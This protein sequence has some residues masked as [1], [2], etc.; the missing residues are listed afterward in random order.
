MALQ[1]EFE[2]QGNWLF[3]YRGSLP[4]VVLAAGLVL[5]LCTKLYPGVFLLGSAQ[6]LYYELACLFISLAGLVIRIFTVGYTPVNTSGRNVKKQ[7]AGKVNT[8]GI[9]SLVRHPLY[10]G[11]FLMW[12]GPTLLTG[13]IWFVVIICLV[14]WLYY[15]RIMFAEE[16]F[17]R[18]KFGAPYL[19]WAQQVPAFL[20]R[21]HG[22]VRP[23]LPF[24]WRKVLKKEKNGF[25]A[26]FLVF[27]LFDVS[28]E[29]VVKGRDFNAVFAAGLAFSALSYLAIKFLKK[30]TRLL[31][32]P[33]R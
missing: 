18:A 21:F 17:L 31:D 11:N 16:Q 10:V 23:D 29:L 27:F 9:Y 14:Y 25:A 13:Q 24:S 26:V 4:L 2:K 20:P 6:G 22:Y 12:M 30:R 28:G 33:G 7:V 15:E 1:E 8:T 3:R 5:Y 32:E 19:D